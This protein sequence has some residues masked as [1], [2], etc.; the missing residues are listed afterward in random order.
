MNKSTRNGLI[1]L[2]VLIVAF[3]VNHN[4]Q[5]G[6]KTSTS[7]MFTGN[8]EN[9][10]KVLIQQGDTAIELNQV[11]GEWSIGGIDT[12]IIRT[13]RIE[14]L[15]TKVLMVKKETP[16]SKNPDKW[17]TYSVD[18]SSGTH[19]ALIDAA[20]E[21]IDYFV[22]GRSK[23]DWSHNY[24]RHGDSPDVF[25]TNES[26]IHFLNTSGSFWGEAPA[27]PPTQ[28]DSLSIKMEDLEEM[29]IAPS[30]IKLNESE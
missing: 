20:G 7:E 9:I 14:S 16:V 4:I 11:N 17:G 19:L 5:S 30:D 8:S 28:P 23:S 12:L 29:G 25:L 2:A 13:D 27:P 3:L 18:D 10:A 1:I 6:R 21:T 24:V 15:L 26:I 22:F